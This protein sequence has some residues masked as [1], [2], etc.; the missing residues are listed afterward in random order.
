MQRVSIWDG[1]W[2]STRTCHVEMCQLITVRRKQGGQEDGCWSCV[3]VMYQGHRRALS[4]TPIC[5][6][7]CTCSC[8]HILFNSHET[9]P[10]PGANS[11]PTAACP[12][13]CQTD[14]QGCLQAGRANGLAYFGR[15]M[16]TNCFPD[17]DSISNI[18][19]SDPG[20]FLSTA[21]GD[22]ILRA[23]GWRG[24]GGAD[25][26]PATPSSA[27]QTWCQDQVPPW[28]QR[29][30]QD[31]FFHFPLIKGQDRAGTGDASVNGGSHRA[32]LL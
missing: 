1:K 16:I 26:Q 18:S 24:V 32:R 23:Q 19:C 9:L 3:S 6:L 29:N 22:T 5:V 15:S 21:S 28:I 30:P 12:V 17:L 13:C 4:V 8:S 7:A 10:G 31:P 20:Q 25:H 2:D 14:W 11:W 27:R